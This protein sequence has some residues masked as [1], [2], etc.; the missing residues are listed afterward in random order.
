MSQA[1][2]AT[3]VEAVAEKYNL[4]ADELRKAL[5]PDTETLMASIQNVLRKRLANEIADEL[6]RAAETEKSPFFGTT[7]EEIM[8]TTAKHLREF[9][10]RKADP[11][12][13][14]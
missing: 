9:K 2:K 11:T 8:E 10:E 13:P 1:E 4:D 6:L 14:E 3:P 5:T 12:E 7:Q